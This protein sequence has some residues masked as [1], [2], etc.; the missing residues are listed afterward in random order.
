MSVD[1]RTINPV[2]LIL[3]VHGTPTPETVG[4]FIQLTGAELVAATII[5][6]AA[7]EANG[8]RDGGGTDGVQLTFK[9]IGYDVSP[10]ALDLFPSRAQVIGRDITETYKNRPNR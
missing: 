1:R 4:Q 5:Y 10:E 3:R 8:R 7:P 2:R 6:G 9:G